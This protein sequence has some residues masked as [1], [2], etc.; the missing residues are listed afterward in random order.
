SFHPGP[1]RLHPPSTLSSD[2]ILDWKINTYHLPRKPHFSLC[3]RLCSYAGGSS[4][5]SPLPSDELSS[6]HL[7]IVMPS[8]VLVG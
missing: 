2:W 6:E 1:H 4:D 7:R 8:Q 3:R 5:P